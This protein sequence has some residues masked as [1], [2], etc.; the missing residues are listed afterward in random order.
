MSIVR[1]LKLARVARK[2]GAKSA[3][4]TLYECRR[5]DVPFSW[6]LA[7][8]EQESFWRN[9]FGCDHGP[10]RAFCHEKVTNAKIRELLAT[11]LANGVGYT[12]LT[13]PAY[14]Q[15]A[16]SRRGGA[17]SVKNQIVVGVKVL[18]EKTGGDMS[19]AWRYNGDPVY[20]RQIEPRAERWH[21]RFRAA[22]LA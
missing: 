16:H 12:Q 22:G 7:M 21:R 8:I 14:V 6:G 11:G 20:Q 5:N 3:L 15:Q 18:A 2:H 1:D 13:S 4:R 19:K 10:G 9:I 17:A